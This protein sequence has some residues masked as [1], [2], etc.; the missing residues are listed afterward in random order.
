MKKK[1]MILPAGFAELRRDLGAIIRRRR[2]EHERGRGLRQAE[3]ADLIGIARESLS[4]IESGR[5][6]PSYDTLYEI[7]GLFDLEWHDVAI[8]GESSRPAR[9]YATENRQ[10]LGAALRAGR[11]E[12]GLSLQAL[13]EKVGISCSQLSRIERAQSTRSRVLEI[14]P[15]GDPQLNDDPVFQFR[16]A[17]FARLAEIGQALD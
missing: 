16:D 17:E 8:K 10:D 1:E 9:R 15:D 6:S 12:E 11:I 14:L 4:R 5:R 13:A 7:M 3:V 2:M